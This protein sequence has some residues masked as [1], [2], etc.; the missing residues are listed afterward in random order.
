MKGLASDYSNKPRQL[1]R[2]K[3]AHAS[4]SNSREGFDGC[5]LGSFPWFAT[6]CTIRELVVG[7]FPE[8]IECW[9]NRSERAKLSQLERISTLCRRSLKQIVRSRYLRE[10]T[11]YNKTGWEI[12]GYSTWL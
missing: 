2:N 11:I 1:A 12:T 8:R 4:H 10:Q 7:E 3:V 9:E 5:N 6:Q